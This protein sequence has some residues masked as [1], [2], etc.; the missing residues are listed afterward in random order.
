MKE[1]EYLVSY[2]IKNKNISGF[3]DTVFSTDKKIN[4]EILE[5]IRK[6]I[7]EMVKNKT[8]NEECQIVIL[9]IVNLTDL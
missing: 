7:G 9:N 3:G 2:N 8:E 4:G 1:K 6:E 5:I